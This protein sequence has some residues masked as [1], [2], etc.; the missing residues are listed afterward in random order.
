MSSLTN[1][2]PEQWQNG[3]LLT[4]ALRQ[5]QSTLRELDLSVELYSDAAPDEVDSVNI[6]PTNGQL[7]PL[8]ELSCLRKLEAPIV[9]LLGWS[10]DELLLPLEEV[11]PAV[12]THLSLAEDLAA[13][14]NYEWNE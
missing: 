7:G 1:S 2:D 13:Q 5:V 8:R 9:M 3:L 10:P 12:L 14:H 11:V 6:R 4:A